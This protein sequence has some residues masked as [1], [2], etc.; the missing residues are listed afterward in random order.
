M[1]NDEVVQKQ[2]HEEAY[3][4]FWSYVEA[5]RIIF[6]DKPPENFGLSNENFWG[7]NKESKELY[8]DMI[9]KPIP[10]YQGMNRSVYSENIYGLSYAQSRRKADEIL[11]KIN[12]EKAQTLLK[13]SKY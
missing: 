4:N 11:N 5:N 9:L 2:S 8:N 7:V 6:V 13:S 10:G 1:I 12:I 3:K